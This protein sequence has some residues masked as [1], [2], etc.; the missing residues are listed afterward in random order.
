MLINLSGLNII[1]KSSLLQTMW[2]SILLCLEYLLISFCN[3]LQS[4]FWDTDNNKISMS[5]LSG[6]IDRIGKQELYRDLDVDRDRGLYIRSKLLKF[7]YQTLF[8]AAEYIVA[9]LLLFVTLTQ[10]LASISIF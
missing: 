7:I 9:F 4:S 10:Q 8:S 2:K 3:F 1:S 6:Y 5:A